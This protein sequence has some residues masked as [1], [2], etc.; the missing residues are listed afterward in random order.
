MND[1][2]PENAKAA[3]KTDADDA[4]PKTLRSEA[5][6]LGRTVGFALL[7][8]LVLRVLLFQPYT[9]P[10]ASMEPTLFEGDYI[11]VSKYIYGWS[12]HSI[13]LSPPLFRGRI[14]SRTP[15]RGDVVVFKFPPDNEKDYIK[16]LIGLPG[17]R[18]Q[19]KA[20]ALFINDKPV[21]RVAD[22]VGEATCPGMGVVSGVQRYQETLPNGRTFH[23]NSCL[24]VSGPADNTG[25]YVVPPN[26]YFMMGDNRDNSSDSRFNPLASPEIAAYNGCPWNPELDQ[27]LGGSGLESGVGF[28]PA[29]NLEGRAELILFSWNHGASLFKPWT[30]ILNARWDRFVH[31]LK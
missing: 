7:I 11:I 30:W 29:E 18:I 22:G 2:S 19:V 14:L 5:V 23:T 31:F 15:S 12:K 28:V 9:I 1:A 4:T 10:S 20:G 25:V 26:C 21:Q 13:P 16:R 17:D 24:G 8:A 6:E 27:A 3:A